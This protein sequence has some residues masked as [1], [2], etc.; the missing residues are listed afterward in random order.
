M[1]VPWLR[2]CDCSWPT[3]LTV[4]CETHCV[5]L[6]P[7]LCSPAVPFRMNSLHLVQTLKAPEVPPR[8]CQVGAWLRA[9]D[10]RTARTLP[11]PAWGTPPQPLASCPGLPPA[12]HGSVV[13]LQHWLCQDSP[14]PQCPHGWAQRQAAAQP[15]EPPRLGALEGKAQKGA[16]DTEVQRDSVARAGE[17]LPGW[18][19]ASSLTCPAPKV[20][21]SLSAAL[22]SWAGTQTSPISSLGTLNTSPQ[23]RS[24]CPCSAAARSRLQVPLKTDGMQ[25]IPPFQLLFKPC[26][27][28]L[29]AAAASH[30]HAGKAGTGAIWG[31]RRAQSIHHRHTKKLLIRRGRQPSLLEECSRGQEELSLQKS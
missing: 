30:T 3:F 13:P 20:T 21:D 22:L 9:R 6:L 31:A 25:I 10:A 7:A 23:P 8:P 17:C 16:R 29:R 24:L 18:Q 12:L 5:L 27:P 2:R 15:R 26:W 1:T 14:R 19:A 28:P 11:P 4:L